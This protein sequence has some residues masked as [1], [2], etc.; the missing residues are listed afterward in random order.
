MSQEEL[1]ENEDGS[2]D[3]LDLPPVVTDDQS[4]FLV[5]LAETLD[6]QEV[7]DLA[8]ELCEQVEKDAESRKKRDKQYEEGLRR[9][10]LGEDAPGGAEFE[11][12]SKVVHPVLAEACVDFSARAIKE[13]FPATGPVRR[14]Q[15]TDQ[16]AP[17]VIARADRKVDY[18][19]WQLSVQMPEYRPSLEQLLTQLPMGGS[20]FQK[21]WFDERFK[22]PRVEFVPVDE[23]LL[24]FSSNCF[25]TATRATHRQLINKYEFR[26]RIASGLY[27]DIFVT[28]P[29]STPERSDT[30]QANDKIEG[31]DDAGYNEDGLRAILEIYTWQIIEGDELAGGEYVPYIIT[32][33]EDTEECLAIYRNWAESDPLFTKLD[34]FV[35]WVF[36]PWRGAYGI[37][38][39]HLIGGLSAA[40]TGALRAL[41]DSAH[42]NNAA[43]MLKL[44]SGRV[45]GQNTTVDVTQVCE[46]EGPAGIDDVRK[47]AMPMPFNPPS[48]VL[49][50]L[51][52]QLYGLAKGV[53]ATA[54]EKMNQVGDRTPVGTTMSLIEQGSV[55]YSAIHSRLHYS[56][57]KALEILH[58]IDATF[59]PPADP[60][61]TDP[62]AVSAD[63]FQGSI[64]VIPVSDPSIFSEA[65]RFA[66][67]QAMVQMGADQSVQWNKHAMYRRALRQMRVDNPD[68][69][70]PPMPQ[71]VTADAAAENA[72]AVTGRQVQANIQQDHLG[73]IQGHLAFVTS[74][75]QLQNPLVPAQSLMA[76]LGHIGQHL[77]MLEQTM[78]I[79]TALSMMQQS[80]MEFAQMQQDFPIAM[81]QAIETGVPPPAPPQQPSPDQVM[82]Q[83]IGQVQQQLSQM[84]APVLQAISQAQPEIQ[85]RMPQP[86]MPPEVQATLQ[87]AQME[88]QRRTQLDQATAAQKQAEAQ[89]SD[90]RLSERLTL[91]QQEAQ[92]QSALDERAMQFDQAL[93]RQRLAMETQAK[94]IENQLRA[95]NDQLVQQI[96]LLKNKTDNDQKQVT[97][98]LKNRDD[99]ETKRDI[100]MLRGQMNLMASSQPAAPI[101]TD[102]TEQFRRMAEMLD[103]IGTKKLTEAL[104][105]VTATLQSTLDH[106]AAPSE[107]IR[108]PQGKAVGIRKVITNKETR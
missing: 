35:E 70:L 14:Q 18:M 91:E 102:F 93:E 23:I 95:Q 20:Q 48:P 76:L 41:L 85:K 5:N 50:G 13:L 29:G 94:A 96:E 43:T 104:G 9:S 33:D 19:N 4:V 15:F 67:T 88:N 69:I 46:I 25:Y 11:G 30:S 72:A 2:V 47:L 61:N 90:Q 42:I 12:A 32:V 49:A 63:D 79:Q 83:A 8:A 54:D 68:E 44:R 66:Q 52:D 106:I 1:I 65:Q 24:P 99:N 56:Q 92:L 16:L 38:L 74:P 6:K 97:E 10:G 27:R 73:H 107:L 87:I 39:P 55:T 77:Q 78:T 62:N 34:W 60:Q 103:Q 58:R 82:A 71:P 105:P 28:D 64:D 80:Q 84:M 26:E 108:D 36:I 51:M 59:M 21:F 101:Q 98:L 37:G 17:E 40:L 100:E 3:I 31:R 81:Q 45:V 89:A 53:V 86:P 22:R 75:L 57:K 7:S